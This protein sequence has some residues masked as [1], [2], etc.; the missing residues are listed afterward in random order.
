MLCNQHIRLV[1]QTD[2]NDGSIAVACNE[3]ECKE[4]LQKQEEKCCQI[5]MKFLI[6]A[7]LL[8]AATTIIVLYSV[9]KL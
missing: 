5:T 6:T 4:N 8:I 2:G 1:D 9:G 7:L 3:G